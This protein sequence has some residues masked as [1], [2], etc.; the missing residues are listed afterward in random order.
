M[1][2]NLKVLIVDDNTG[3]REHLRRLFESD[4]F[5]VTIEAENGPEAIRLAREHQPNLITL[6]VSM[7][8]MTGLQ[9]APLIR[10]FLASTPIILVTLY[11]DELKFL[12][13]KALGISA[14][15]SKRHPLDQLLDIAHKLVAAT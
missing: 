13:L 14:I 6:D 12:D 7:P 4:G 9:V 8:G 15:F 10:E 2:Q 11:G 3:M 5:P 1:K